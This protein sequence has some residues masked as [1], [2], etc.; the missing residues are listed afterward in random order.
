[1]EIH[2]ELFIQHKKNIILLL[3]LSLLTANLTYSQSKS[4]VKEW[5]LKLNGKRVLILGDSITQDGT[6]V[7]FLEYF[8]ETMYPEENFNIISI[9]LS[10][11]TASGLSEPGSRFPRPCIFSRLDSALKII[12]PDVVTACYGM[13]DGIYSPQSPERFKAFKN[14]IMNLIKKIRAAGAELILLTPPVFDTSAST[15]NVQKDNAKEYGF[16]K[17]YYKYD[18]VLTD[19]SNWIMGLR[20]K[21]LKTIDLH[22]AM[23][24]YL[25]NRRRTEPEFKINK[26]GVHPTHLGHLLMAEIFLESTGTHIHFNNL[27]EELAKVSADTLYKLINKQRQ[28]R[29]KGWLDYI[30]YTRGKSVKTNDIKQTEDRVTELQ[31]QIDL[32]KR[33][34]TMH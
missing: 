11:E 9:G 28:L 24:S 1:M 22:R 13:N 27:D 7:S 32:L 16:S 3:V 12:K 17:P 18:K 26:D 31:K 19:Y 6:Y 14:G 30:G 15:H 4:H 34:S 33:G 20:I 5:K 25:D 29:S 21:D 10:S 8:L 2:F 23:K